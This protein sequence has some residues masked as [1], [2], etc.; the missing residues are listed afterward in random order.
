MCHTERERTHLAD[1]DT[2]LSKRTLSRSP[3]ANFT[4]DTYENRRTLRYDTYDLNIAFLF[5]N[6]KLSLFLFQRSF[7][8]KI[9]TL[10]FLNL[11]NR[12]KIVEIFVDIFES[13]VEESTQ[14]STKW[15]E[16]SQVCY[17]IIG[18]K[19]WSRLELK[20]ERFLLSTRKAFGRYI[21][22]LLLFTEG[23]VLVRR[24]EAAP[25]LARLKYCFSSPPRRRLPTPCLF[26]R[27]FSNWI[28]SLHSLRTTR[29]KK[30]PAPEE[31]LD[32][33]KK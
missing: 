22:L 31:K 18:G 16:V 14:N 15:R 25:S 7:F 33:A 2:F 26:S 11:K 12:S 5:R 20:G 8:E 30:I 17:T 13:E 28:A 27:I 24:D 10:S 32:C 29:R 6:W 3:N 4:I 23:G 19:G 21:H 9:K 1:D